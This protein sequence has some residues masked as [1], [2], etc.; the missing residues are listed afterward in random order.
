VSNPSKNHHNRGGIPPVR[1]PG[2]QNRA[3]YTTFNYNSGKA[4]WNINSSCQDGPT[5]GNRTGEANK[6]LLPVGYLID[7]EISTYSFQV[8]F[9]GD[10]QVA[11]TGEKK[12]VN[13]P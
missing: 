13:E 12:V 8:G 9:L 1:Y 4:W 10:E 5:G 11:R 6:Q 2:G 3:I 7:L